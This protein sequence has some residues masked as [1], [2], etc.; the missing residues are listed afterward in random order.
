MEGQ[1]YQLG[2]YVDIVVSIN[3]KLMK[4]P[5]DTKVYPGHGYPTIIENERKEDFYDTET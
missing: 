3:N 2:S 4:L 5:I 1:I